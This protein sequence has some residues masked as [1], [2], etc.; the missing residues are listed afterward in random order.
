[1]GDRHGRRGAGP[2]WR[3]TAGLLALLVAAS[4]ASPAGAPLRGVAT[5]KGI[6]DRILDADFDAAAAAIR[7]CEGAP[8]EACDALEA[9]RIWWQILLDPESTARD[10]AFQ[11]AVNAAIASAEAW[12]AR[13]GRSAE[14]WFYLGGAYGARVQWRVLRKEYLAAARDGKR[15]KEALERALALDASLEDANFG[16]GLY[17]Y[18]A[19]VAPA[20]AKIL[21]VLLLLPG[22]DRVEGLKRMLRARERG[23]V[24]A[25]EAAYQ[26]HVID[27]WYEK[28]FARA[29]GLL[30]GLQ[31]DHPRN[32]LFTQLIAEV[33][34]VY[35]HDRTASLEAWRRIIDL[36]ARGG[37]NEAGVATARARLGAAVQLDALYETDAAIDL[38]EPLVASR[39][40]APLGLASQAALQLGRALDRMGERERALAAYAAAA[41]AVP[42]GDPHGVRA[43]VRRAQ[44]TPPPA[45]VAR[46]YRLSLAGWRALERRDLP[47]AER[48]LRD[49]LALRG[50]DPV[51]RYRAAQVWLAR[52]DETAALRDL[53]FVIAAA[54][55]EAPT[56]HARACLDAAQLLERRG[57]G[58]RALVL[59][60]RGASVFGAAE[61]TKQAAARAAERLRAS[62]R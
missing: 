59:Y 52:H 43:A 11:R 53:E 5:I 23:Q 41:S 2:G 6:Y 34:D 12:T 27:L 39:P 15:I 38:L 22:G 50:H 55:P 61:A 4:P 48:A 42:P 18:Y 31:R 37:L 49:A 13:E 60:Q 16:I 28:Q 36:G 46:A 26:L 7:A 30:R 62:G 51:T 45:D 20:A 9:T 29:L 33:Q 17:E 10:A 58:A 19:D 44:R 35:F 8:R 47:A 1:M 25:G 56:F 40:T 24:L 32:P 3:A 14:A 57:D 21:R 54:P